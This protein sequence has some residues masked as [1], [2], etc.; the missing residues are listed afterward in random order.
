MSEFVAVEQINV[1]RV[2]GSSKES[3]LAGSTPLCRGEKGTGSSQ[4]WE[5]AADI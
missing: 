2:S 4:E 3:A 5:F 1:S